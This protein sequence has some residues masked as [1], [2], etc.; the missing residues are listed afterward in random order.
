MNTLEPS[1]PIVLARTIRAEWARLWTLRSMWLFMLV[2][3]IVVG[4]SVLIG[5]DSPTEASVESAEA[6]WMPIR[7]MSMLAMLL[8]LPMA[9][10]GTTADYGTGGIVPT[11][12]WTPRRESL[13]AARSI[14]II[15]AVSITGLIPALLSAVLVTQFAPAQSW[16]WGAGVDALATLGFVSALGALVAVGV[17]L[18][19]RSTAASIG[20]V[21]GLVLIL[22]LLLGNLPFTWAK[23]VAALLPGTSARKLMIGEGLPGLTATDARIALAAW[24]IGALLLGGW[25]LLRTDANR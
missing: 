25:R 3:T 24:A 20:T 19:L 22:P 7:R 6:A 9:T 16:S 14:A 18:L 12:Q 11:M 5:F 23:D 21:L 4:I 1:T 17:G 13:L 15:L 10:V 8:L 2:T